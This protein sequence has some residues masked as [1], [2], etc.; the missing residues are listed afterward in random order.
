MKKSHIFIP[1]VLICALI[2]T[3]ILSKISYTQ[4]ET[5]DSFIFPSNNCID[6]Y[7]DKV[8][9]IVMPN[10]KSHMQETFSQWGITK[11][12]F[13]D[14][15]DKSKYTHADFISKNLL[16]SAY[17]PYLNLGRICCHVSALTVYNNF[18]HS[19]AKNILIFEDDLYKDEYKNKSEFNN[20]I[21]PYL[22]SI[23]MNW[24]YLNL[25]KCS[26]Y[27]NLSGELND[28]WSIPFR[29][30]CRTAIALS[31][32]AAKS[33]LLNTS[34]MKEIPGDVMISELIKR[35][36]F[37]AYSSNTQLFKQDRRNFGSHLENDNIDSLTMCK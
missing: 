29:P 6:A 25:G 17:S 4:R 33:I 21:Q 5:F 22:E 9:C 24:D 23:P 31:K 36:M 13:F 2:I 30:L 27:C 35:K 19:N 28:Y 18:M 10:R 20:K 32:H 11:V 15:I 3:I 12:E 34:F 14:A 16:S 37:K 7:F 8:V 26:D 1:F